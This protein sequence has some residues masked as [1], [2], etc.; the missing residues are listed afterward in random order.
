P[1]DRLL[2]PGDLL[3]GA[4]RPDDQR[5]GQPGAD[6][7]DGLHL[8]ADADQRGGQLP[9]AE[10]LG[11]RHVLPQPRNREPH[12]TSM[13]NALLNRRSP[14]TMSRMSPTPCRTCR[15]R[16]IPMPNANPVY[17]SGSMPQATSTRGLTIPQPPHSIQPSDLQVRHGRSGLPTEAPRQA[18]HW[19]SNSADGSVN[20]KYDGRHRVASPAPSMGAAR[21]SRVPFRWAI[22]MPP[23]TAGPSTRG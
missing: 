8:Q 21:G 4:H 6:L 3:E 15:V 18:K 11:Q 7:L 19:M 9:R 17:R 13:P 23:S 12:Q 5:A 22:V 10:R 1:A 2:R 16:S 14:S 20:G